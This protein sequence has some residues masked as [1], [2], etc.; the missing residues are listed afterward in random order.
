[1]GKSLTSFPILHVLEAF[2]LCFIHTKF[3]K[4]LSSKSPELC[5]SPSQMQKQSC[6]LRSLFGF[7]CLFIYILRCSTK[8]LNKGIPKILFFTSH[9]IHISSSRIATVFNAMLQYSMCPNIEIICN[10][11]TFIVCLSFPLFSMQTWMLQAGTCLNSQH[12]VT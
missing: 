6:V 7:F 5:R 3:N 11:Q 9:V 2:P 12:T 4:S 10:L 1:M 8:K